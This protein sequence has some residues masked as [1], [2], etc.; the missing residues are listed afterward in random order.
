LATSKRLKHKVMKTKKIVI[1]FLFM[2]VV[3]GM[4]A[5]VISLPPYN[6]IP[7][8]LENRRDFPPS[9]AGY[10]KDVNGHFNKFI[11]TWEYNGSD[12]YLKVQFYKVEVVPTWDDTFY[13]RL[14]S[15]IEYKEKR[16][17]Q[18]ITIY[19]T[20]GSAI[21]TNF[22]FNYNTIQGSGILKNNINWIVLKYTEP[23]EG[24]REFDGTLKLKY[25]VDSNPPQLIWERE[26]YLYAN[27]IDCGDNVDESDFK[28]PAN[29]I[30]TKINP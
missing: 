12:K 1:A 5:Q 17:G 28:I 21:Q 25:Q 2:M 30:L 10:F 9:S 13:D 29:M 19:N 20:F 14:C 27:D 7:I 18:W 22:N 6:M 15:F 23:S 24:C 4:N 11:G 16:N 3:Q 26:F 8:P